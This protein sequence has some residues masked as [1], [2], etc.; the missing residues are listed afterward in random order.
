MNNDIARSSLRG[1]EDERQHQRLA[2][3]FV[4]RTKRA[5]YF[6]K[7]GCGKTRTGLR[8]AAAIMK[9]KPQARVLIV[10]YKAV[11][12][13]VPEREATQW[14][15]LADLKFHRL[16]EQEG[17]DALLTDVPGVYLANWE[18]L[19]FIMENAPKMR[20]FTYVWCDESAGIKNPRSARTKAVVGICKPAPYVLLTTG[21]PRGNNIIDMWAQIFCV[22]PE[23]AGRLEAFKRKYTTEDYKGRTVSLPGADD[24]VVELI[25]PIAITFLNDDVLDLPPLQ[26]VPRYVTLPD[27]AK[28]AIAQLE[29]TLAALVDGAKDKP[30]A[31]VAR[32]IRG[33]LT[34]IRQMYSGRALS[35]TPDDEVR[36]V[37]TIHDE[38]LESLALLVEQLGDRRLFIVC[39]FKATRDAILTDLG[40]QAC[41]LDSGNVAEVLARWNDDSDPLRIVVANPASVGQGVDGFQE[42]GHDM[43]FFDPVWSGIALEQTIARLYRSGATKPV[44][45]WHILAEGDRDERGEYR[46][47]LDE[48]MLATA[49]ARVS[50]QD[51]LLQAVAT[52][53]YGEKAAASKLDALREAV[54]QA[55]RDMQQS[56]PDR[57]PDAADGAAF[58]E[59]HKR[60]ERA[61]ADLEQEQSNAQP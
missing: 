35:G 1:P 2:Y 12:H 58:R 44:T 18:R 6:G 31:V 25:K 55:R 34:K 40:E 33:V 32:G 48:L 26:Q 9:A 38:K 56:H 54:Q 24:Q 5:L 53:L 28:A 39:E 19:P 7:P 11:V 15:D 8:V 20:P 42:K 30:G 17:R 14:T 61:R 29:A 21:T 22:H 59:A 50:A 45:V 10:S 51:A 47:S 41:A 43:V 37:L 23:I 16:W 60:Y 52:R 46:R 13:S 49:Q 27:D 4:A 3:D 36:D 57:N